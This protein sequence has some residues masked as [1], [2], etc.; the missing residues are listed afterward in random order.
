MV[1][2]RSVQQAQYSSAAIIRLRDIENRKL[3][4]A[5]SMDC[6]PRVCWLWPEE[7]G[8]RAVAE[9]AINLATKGAEPI[10]L[11]DCL[12]FGNPEN[13]E[14]MWE[15]EKAVDGISQACE[16][17]EI[18]VVSGNVS[19]YNDTDKKPIY[20]TP[21]IGMVGLID[22]SISIPESSFFSPWL[23]IAMIGNQE[24]E[25]GGSL[26][27][28]EWFKKDCGKPSE[29]DLDEVARTI[30]FCQELC[31]KKLSVA[32][33]DVSEGGVVVTAL[34]M[35]FDSPAKNIG[36][37][38][39]IA[40]NTDIDRFLFGETVPRLLLAYKEQ[41]RDTIRQLAESKNL[42]IN[43][44]GKSTSDDQVL[45][46]RQGKSLFDTKLSQIKDRWVHKW[47]KIFE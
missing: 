2:N 33:Q 8:R 15:F 44:I 7:G 35:A 4:L 20:P 14:V 28:K 39:E 16:K 37:T 40:E 34:E 47:D 29:T 38:L 6:T 30:S 26:F 43:S 42:S 9:S 3:S 24:G 12:N 46:Q 22:E 27:A 41:D 21:M 23:E 11:T 5:L 32:I 1:G 19:L 31:K 10:G 36:V 45:I 25:I 13:P 18:P 17:L